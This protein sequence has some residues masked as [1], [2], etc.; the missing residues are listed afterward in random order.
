MVDLSFVANAFQFVKYVFDSM[1]SRYPHTHTRTQNEKK[2]RHEIAADDSFSQQ[3]QQQQQQS[4]LNERFL[5]HAG[6]LASALIETFL[7]CLTGFSVR[8]RWLCAHPPQCTDAHIRNWFEICYRWNWWMPP[9]FVYA[10]IR[11][12]QRLLYFFVEYVH[13]SISTDRRRWVYPLKAA[14]GG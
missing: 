12:R 3:Q 2:E 7:V 6:T 8:Y 11:Q 9:A 13:L 4:K 10:H 1:L 5:I 14:K